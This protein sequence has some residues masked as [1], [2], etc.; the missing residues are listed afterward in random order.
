MMVGQMAAGLEVGQL[1]E[2]MVSHC[3]FLPVMLLED[4]TN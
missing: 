4:M 2:G 1:I 3:S